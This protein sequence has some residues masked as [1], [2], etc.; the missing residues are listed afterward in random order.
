MKIFVYNC[1]SYLL[2]PSCFLKIKAPLT[3][4][5]GV[6]FYAL[7]SVQWGGSLVD[8]IYL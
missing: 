7:F 5:K 4:A 8:K 1:T 3:M 6:T 2:H